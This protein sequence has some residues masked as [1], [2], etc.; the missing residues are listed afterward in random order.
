MALRDLGDTSRGAIGA[1][2]D[3]LK[4]DD[5]CVRIYSAGT[6]LILGKGDDKHLQILIDG[7]RTEDKEKIEAA[8]TTFVK[9]GVPGFPGLLICL[10]DKSPRVRLSATGGFAGAFREI[11]SGNISVLQFFQF[12]HEIPDDT[13]IALAAAT[14]DENVDVAANAI[15]ALS[16]CGDKAKKAIPDII[17]CLK[18]KRYGVRW[19]AACHLKEFGASATIAI[20]A[21]TEALQDSEFNVRREAA[22]SLEEIQSAAKK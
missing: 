6:L 1:I 7:L 12:K 11:R 10:K 9:V 2:F 21:L 13:I 20:P 17:K 16:V 22:R 18:D 4:D 8:R 14:N 15:Y 5:E 3:S 19:S